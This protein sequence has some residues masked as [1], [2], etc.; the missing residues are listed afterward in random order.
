M[1]SSSEKLSIRE[2]LKDEIAH[3][4]AIQ[5]AS[6]TIQIS[7]YVFTGECGMSLHPSTIGEILLIC[8]EW[9][10]HLE[11]RNDLLIFKLPASAM[12]DE[13][14]FLNYFNYHSLPIIS[15]SCLDDKPLSKYIVARR[16]IAARLV[17]EKILEQ[18]AARLSELSI[19][20]RQLDFDYA[21]LH[22]LCGGTYP[23]PPKLEVPDQLY[24]TLWKYINDFIDRSF[25]RI[26]KTNITVQPYSSF[27]PGW[28]L[29]MKTS[30]DGRLPGFSIIFPEDL[31][32]DVD[33]RQMIATI[34]KTYL[35]LHEV[36]DERTRKLEG[37]AFQAISE[38]NVEE[39]NRIMGQIPACRS[40][41]GHG[42]HIRDEPQCEIKDKIIASAIGKG[43]KEILRCIFKHLR[44]HARS[45]WCLDL[46]RA[47]GIDDLASE[48]W[49]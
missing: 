31:V 45:P 13:A 33:L 43:N 7:R 11:I 46:L 35:L 32:E 9:A 18:C 21:E 5:F 28:P 1:A 15:S 49:I 39:L 26:N 40:K 8:E 37:E 41:S 3:H 30:H 6:N 17:A 16:N 24:E 10:V 14:N 48:V 34:D 20:N 47:S 25:F 23:G 36:F 12:L 27:G 29:A 2:I 22:R 4:A 38:G 42:E 44:H 19:D